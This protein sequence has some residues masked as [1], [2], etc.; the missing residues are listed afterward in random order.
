MDDHA[1]HAP[2]ASEQTASDLVTK[3]EGYGHVIVILTD[4]PPDDKGDA[5]SSRLMSSSMN[6]ALIADI[7][8]HHAEVHAKM[9]ESPVIFSES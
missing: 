4:L 3:L 9:S 1:P 7:L 6:H 5:C 8:R 2:H